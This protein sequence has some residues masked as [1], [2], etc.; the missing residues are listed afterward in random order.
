VTVSYK[1][2]VEYDA[3]IATVPLDKITVF[4][5]IPEGTI[6]DSSDGKYNYEPEGNKVSWNLSEAG[7]RSG[8]TLT[9]KPTKPDFFLSM[10]VYATAEGQAG[11]PVPS[12]S[13]GPPAKG[14]TC[15]VSPSGYCTV[16]FLKPYFNGNEENARK[17]SIICNRESGGVPTSINRN[18]DTN[19]YSV[20]L[21]QINLV[22]HC[23]G[24]YGS[25]KHGKQSCDNLLSE[26]K[27]SVCEKQLLDPIE[28]IKKMVSLSSNGTYW[29]PW[30]T[31]VNNSCGIF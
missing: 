11:V 8:F 21:F 15:S 13:V 17:A 4:S 20:G 18:C 26:S 25:G 3:A 27:R 2:I 30:Y 5:D 6:F 19:D 9:L 10:K 28:N 22:A 1:I 14:P 24:A 31:P 7:N 23:A 16:A 29:R 12:G